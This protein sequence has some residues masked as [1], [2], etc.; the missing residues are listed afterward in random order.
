MDYSQYKSENY[1]HNVCE[2]GFIEKS[3]VDKSVLT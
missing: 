1:L 3:F 2:Y